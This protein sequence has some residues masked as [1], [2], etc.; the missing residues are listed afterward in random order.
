[1]NSHPTIPFTMAQR[2]FP[3]PPAPKPAL[4]RCVCKLRLR[5]RSGQTAGVPVTLTPQ[6]RDP[7]PAAP[8]LT[9]PGQRCSGFRAHQAPFS[10]SIARLGSDSRVDSRDDSCATLVQIGWKSINFLFYRIASR[11]HS[12]QSICAD[13]A[14]HGYGHSISG[15]YVTCVHESLIVKNNAELAK[16]SRSNDGDIALLNPV[17]LRQH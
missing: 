2:H 4:P 11:I 7:Q 12:V 3:I 14:I 5:V 16:N 13:S 8:S 9:Q 15:V 17:S 1:M 6:R 10:L